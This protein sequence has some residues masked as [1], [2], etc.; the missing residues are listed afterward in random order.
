L[1]FLKEVLSSFPLLRIKGSAEKAAATCAESVIVST[2][3]L[4]PS[5]VKF[6]LRRERVDAFFFS[7]KEE[8]R[9]SFF[10]KNEKNGN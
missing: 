1:F 9:K 8:K 4:S 10:E 5:L 3:S 7:Q 6:F 2:L